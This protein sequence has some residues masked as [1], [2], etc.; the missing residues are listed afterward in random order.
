MTIHR[1]P[2]AGRILGLD[3]KA[4][5]TRRWYYFVPAE[6]RAEEAGAPHRAGRLDGLPARR[7]G[8]RAGR[9]LAAGLERMLAGAHRL[10]MQ[11][12]PNNA[13]M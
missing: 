6:G 11:L 8:I 5:I 1:D 2:I 9:K 7:R 13:I 4:H 12:S 10:A 3:E